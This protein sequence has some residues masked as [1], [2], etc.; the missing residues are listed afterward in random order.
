MAGLFARFV[1]SLSLCTA[2][3]IAWC[4][5]RRDRWVEVQSRQCTGQELHRGQDE[6]APSASASPL[7]LPRTDVLDFHIDFLHAPLALFC[8]S[9]RDE[10]ARPS[11]CQTSCRF[12]ACFAKCRW[13]RSPM[14]GAATCPKTESEPFIK[15][16]RA[17]FAGAVNLK[18]CMPN[19]VP[20]K[21]A[22]LKLRHSAIFCRLSQR[23]RYF[24]GTALGRR[25]WRR[26]RRFETS[27]AKSCAK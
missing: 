5:E 13:S 15:G 14:V 10:A 23:R 12:T 3:L 20:N 4:S 22:I 19:P 11:R 16:F 21:A 18:L 25:A 24:P 7:A 27:C 17:I 26:R 1:A 2:S 9:R 8:S 6:V